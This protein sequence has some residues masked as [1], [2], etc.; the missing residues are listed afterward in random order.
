MEKRRP[1]NDLHARDE[2]HVGKRIRTD[3]AKNGAGEEGAQALAPRAEQMGGNLPEAAAELAGDHLQR[4][5][6]GFPIRG[7]GVLQRRRETVCQW[8]RY[9]H[10]NTIK[11]I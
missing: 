8:W 10:D 6:Y 4:F 1:V 7:N 3:G 2:L 5:L 9:A 11:F